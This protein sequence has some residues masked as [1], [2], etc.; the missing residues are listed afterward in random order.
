MSNRLADAV[1]PYLRSHADNPV[2]WWPWCEEAFAEAARRDVPV[3]VSIGYSTCHWCHVMARESFSDPE[4][5]ALL[6]DRVVAVKVDREE[7]PDVDA[8]YLAAASAFVEGLGWPLTV[9][10][11]PQGHAFF[12]GTYYPPEPVQGHPS[13]RQ[14]VEA[15]TEAWRDR[16]P[17]VDATAADVAEALAAG[18]LASSDAGHAAALPSRPE[19][20]R[21][22]AQLAQHEDVEHGGFGGAPKFPVAPAQLFLLTTAAWGDATSWGLAD[23]TLRRMAA[24]PLRDPVEGGFFRYSVRRDWHEPHYE[25]M[26]TDNALLLRAYSRLAVLDGDPPARAVPGAG[27]G[28][29]DGGGTPCTGPEPHEVVEGIAD[30]LL[31]TLR[32][33][34]GA[35]GAGQDSESTIDG[36]RDEGGYYARDAAGRADLTP[37]PVDDKVLTGWNGLA[38]GALAEAGARHGRRDWVD[39]ARTAAEVVLTDHLRDDGRLLRAST[40]SGTSDAVA[41]LED[42]GMLAEGLLAL[43]LATGEPRWAVTARRL[44]DACLLPED[45]PRVAAA[46]DGPDPLLVSHGVALAADPTEGAYPSGL[47]ATAAAAFTLFQ[48]TA[49]PRYR[50]AA[51]RAVASRVEAALDAPVA[52][53]TT[54]MLAARL[55]APATQIVVVT[56][57]SPVAP[58]AEHAPAPTPSGVTDVA[59]P[60]TEPAPA[61]S[62]VPEAADPAVSDPAGSGAGADPGAAA[63]PAGTDEGERLAWCARRVLTPGSLAVVVPEAAAI[64][65]AAAGFELFEGRTALDGRA[66]AYLCRDFV[67]R[68]PVT[69]LAS[70]EADLAVV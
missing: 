70:F 24:S 69:D 5:A 21:S 44:V 16:R 56:P 25:R 46:P 48:L 9:F 20:L 43:T 11:T 27:P 3:M 18:Q 35:F 60:A 37:P 51:Q 41:T 57:E 29:A 55:A 2:D 59:D 31:T 45:D 63:S 30:F 53:G 50:R 62:S 58:A 19:L 67:C 68:L 32:T 49:D 38:I 13:F 66:T 4:I 28:E 39:A 10:V 36:R 33:P 14:V 1:S 22:V 7:H 64:E 42:H 12:A 26:L 47:A 17:Q 54:A 34:R 15:V 8:S 6:A 40:A 65:L 61:P 52:H 23:R